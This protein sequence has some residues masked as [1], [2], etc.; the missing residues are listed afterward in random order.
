MKPDS[1]PDI[2][3]LDHLRYE[4]S[5]LITCKLF[6]DLNEPNGQVINIRPTFLSEPR[7][8][9][10]LVRISFFVLTLTFFLWMW[11]EYYQGQNRKIYL[12][13]LTRW[14][15]LFSIFY[16]A[17]SIAV[18]IWP[19]TTLR[20]PTG[21]CTSLHPVLR[22]KWILYSS[23]LPIHLLSIMTFWFGGG[24]TQEGFNGNDAFPRIMEHGVIFLFLL[25]DGMVLHR[26]PIR[27][28]HIF[29]TYAICI[30]YTLFY[31]VYDR[32]CDLG[33]GDWPWEPEGDQTSLY[34]KLNWKSEWKEMLGFVVF[35]HF[36]FLPCSFLLFWSAALYSGSWKFDGSHRHFFEDNNNLNAD[37]IELCQ[38]DF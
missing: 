22:L 34:G 4:L 16:Q 12:A 5:S 26:F 8:L 11:I 23:L 29:L 27:W 21:T 31:I 38:D 6:F 2:R 20:Q 17:L 9:T 36:F 28:K 24:G 33:D 30:C 7:I 25:I 32:S 15:I 35:V 14:V 37:D 13:F 10:G 1:K 19:N 3:Y 18:T